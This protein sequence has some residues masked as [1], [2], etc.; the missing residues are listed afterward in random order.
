MSAD[1][2]LNHAEFIGRCNDAYTFECAKNEAF[3]AAVFYEPRNTIISKEKDG[4]ADVICKEVYE[5]YPLW[6]LDNEKMLENLSQKRNESCRQKKM[7]LSTMVSVII[8]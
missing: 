4:A 7:E 5:V 3:L 6:Y 2:V 8:R 1:Y